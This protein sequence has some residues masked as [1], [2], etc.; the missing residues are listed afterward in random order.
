MALHSLVI[1]QGRI[2]NKAFMSRVGKQPIA[3]PPGV[4]VKMTGSVLSVKGPKGVLTL[5]IP[6]DLQAK[7]EAGKLL[8]SI[9]RPD[10]PKLGAWHGL[11][12][13][14][15]ANM[16][17]GVVKGYAKELEIQ[18][19]GFKAAVQGKKM[20]FS[21]GFAKPVE[22]TIPDGVDVKVT[23]NVKLL[24][25]GP[26]KQ[27]VGDLAASIKALFPAEPYKGKGIRFKG[28]HVRRKVG[29]TVA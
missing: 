19:V 18:G 27:R 12:R 16:V 23:E 15:A 9:D 10:D 17:E 6:G 22:K 28:E 3:I 14:L 1:V 2:R 24:V 5:A 26:D 4:E 8:L 25:S 21:L 20:V 13:S 11:F 29:K 7:V